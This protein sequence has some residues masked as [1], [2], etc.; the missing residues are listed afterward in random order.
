MQDRTP[1]APPDNPRTE[2]EPQHDRAEDTP[3]DALPPLPQRTRG[4]SL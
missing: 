3:A 2:P 1:G 4:G